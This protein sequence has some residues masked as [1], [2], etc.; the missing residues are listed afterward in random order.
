MSNMLALL[1]DGDQP[2]TWFLV[3]FLLRLPEWMHRQLKAGRYQTPDEMGFAADELWEPPTNINSTT[4]QPSGKK[5]KR[6]QSRRQVAPQAIPVSAMATSP[7][8]STCNFIQLEDKSTGM[9][10]LVDTGAALS[11]LPHKSTMPCTGTPL[12]SANGSAIKAWG[13]Q[14]QTVTFGRSSF[15]I[16]F[17]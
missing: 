7:T 10:F 14:N 17:C 15:T 13:F 16:N 9:Q 6:K 3:L 5:R 4:T 8:A 1:P 12:V 11:L 2:G